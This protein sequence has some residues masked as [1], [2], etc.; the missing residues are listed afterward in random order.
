MV[1][2]LLYFY[3]MHLLISALAYQME[4]AAFALFIFL[5]FLPCIPIAIWCLI[6]KRSPSLFNR[7]QQLLRTGAGQDEL[8]IRELE[9]QNSDC[10]ESN[11]S[12]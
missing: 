12:G 11:N 2:F 7:T 3:S 8:V 6:A 5:P 10:P 1:N 4:S 9:K